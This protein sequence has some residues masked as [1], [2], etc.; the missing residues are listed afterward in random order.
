VQ[1][2]LPL[3]RIQVTWLTL[4]ED[5]SALILIAANQY[6][7]K[8]QIENGKKIKGLTLFDFISFFRIDLN[9]EK[10]YLPASH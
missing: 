7:F 9:L 3:S 6:F 2:T 4:S 5:N 8:K 10:Q 1:K